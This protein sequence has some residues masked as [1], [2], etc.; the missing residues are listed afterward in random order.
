MILEKQC[1]G[2]TLQEMEG[3]ESQVG[4]AQRPLTLWDLCLISICLS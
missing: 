2:W 1:L 4:I 3:L